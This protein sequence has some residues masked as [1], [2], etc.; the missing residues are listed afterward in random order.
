MGNK[1]ALVLMFIVLSGC[2]KFG[3]SG[4]P[5]LN[6]GY[7][8]SGGGELQP[9]SDKLS[10]DCLTNPEFDACVF[11]K[12]PVSQTQSQTAAD[13]TQLNSLRKFG[14]KLRGLSRTGFLENAFVQ[15]QTL[16]S[17]RV[18]LYQTGKFKEAIADGRTSA[19]QVMT[20]YWANR[21]I[22]YL[23]ARIGV[24]FLPVRNLKIYVDDVFTGY[25]SSNNS[26]H[27]QKQA[28]TIPKAFSADVVLQLLGQAVAHELSGKSALNLSNTAKH[29]FCLLSPKGCCAADVGC[30]N[31]L[32]GSAG[33][34]LTGIMFPTRPSIGESVAGLVGGQKLCDLD[35]NLATLSTKTKTQIYAAC[36]KTPGHT[37][38]MGAWYASLW[39]KVR[40]EAEVQTPG[41]GAADV[42]K[43]FF[44]HA[45]SW[46]AAS[47]FVDAK[48][49]TLE[50]ASTYQSGKYLSLFNSVFAAA[51][52]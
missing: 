51:G 17:P 4:G 35:R 27:L 23:S 5:E 28:G 12:N 25:S 52:L 26:I 45:K 21:A 29:N 9:S 37:V 49:K 22:E 33:D 19:E 8:A 7:F 6:Q 46:T 11:L 48:S 10:E 3:T 15:I 2:S 24:E 30:A 50:L 18:P 13:Q 20:Y 16:G 34:Y 44:E 14:I 1:V 36:T 41:S 47:T 32:T 39:W 38:L 40:G 42:D 31:A 43:L